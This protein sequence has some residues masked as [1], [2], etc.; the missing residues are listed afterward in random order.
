MIPSPRHGG[1]SWSAVAEPTVVALDELTRLDDLEQAVRAV[2]S[3]YDFTRHPYFTWLAS[4]RADRERFLRSQLPFRFAVEA[5]SQAL[6]AVLARA[7][8]LEIR[9][10]LAE[11]VAEEHGHGDPS[12]SHKHTFEG[13]LRALGAD[14]ALLHAPC[15]VAVHAFNRSLLDHCLV[16]RHEVGAVLLGIIEYL[17]VAISH[18]IAQTIDERRWVGDGAQGHYR[19]HEALDPVHARDLFALA[20][21][22]WEARWLRPDIAQALVLGAHHFWRLYDELHRVE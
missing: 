1:V 10:G 15:P 21:P 18:A 7:P 9:M 3:A 22:A 17:Y 19:L 8:R 4:P 12:R 11:N 14:P 2:A 16:E 6:A 20:R 13:F 5:F